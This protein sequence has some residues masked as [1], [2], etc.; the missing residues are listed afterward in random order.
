[1]N[2]EEWKEGDMWQIWVCDPASNVGWTTFEEKRFEEDARRRCEKLS[3]SGLR[4]EWSARKVENISRN[5]YPH[6]SYDAIG[7]TFLDCME[8]C[9]ERLVGDGIV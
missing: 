5:E 2:F 8:E 1:M 3:T 4:P 9:F 6:R 7:M